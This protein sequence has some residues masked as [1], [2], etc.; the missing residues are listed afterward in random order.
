MKVLDTHARKYVQPI[1]QKAAKGFIYFNISANQ[2]TWLALIIGLI[3]GIMVYLQQP[4]VAVILLWLSG[5]LDVVD[6][7]VAREKNQTSAWGTLIDITFDRIVELV[8]I[9]SLAIRYEEAQLFLLILTAGI[10]F[11]MTV[12]LTVGAL[13]EK[14]GMK[15]FY[16]QAGL[17]ER[18]EGFILLSLMILFSANGLIYVTGIFIIV[19]F[20][21]GLQRL[22]EARKLFKNLT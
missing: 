8:V 22:L 6:G 7:S 10:V 20:F 2:I 9:V 5:F 11:S 15:S 3:S 19:E 4:I 13:T 18:T 12:F 17:A 21:T 1:I 16:Y 14:S